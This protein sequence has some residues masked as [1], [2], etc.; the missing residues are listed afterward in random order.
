MAIR[1]DLSP[2]FQAAI[3]R[4]ADTVTETPQPTGPVSQ[5]P[6]QQDLISTN[7]MILLVVLAVIIIIIGVWLNRDRERENQ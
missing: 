2:F 7:F 6:T 4:I 3:R 1:I 5:V